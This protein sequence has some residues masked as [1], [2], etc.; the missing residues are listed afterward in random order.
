MQCSAH[1]PWALIERGVIRNQCLEPGVWWEKFEKSMET[2]KLCFTK[3]PVTEPWFRMMQKLRNSKTLGFQKKLH[4]AL[5]SSKERRELLRSSIDFLLKIDQLQVTHTAI[6]VLR[7]FVL[8]SAHLNYSNYWKYKFSISIIQ[9]K[10]ISGPVMNGHFLE[11]I[12]LYLNSMNQNIARFYCP[13][14]SWDKHVVQTFCQQQKW[15]LFNFVS[16]CLKKKF[17]I[18]Q[19]WIDISILFHT[20]LMTSA[21]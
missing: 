6:N 2:R 12:D 9:I 18:F 14:F 3:V 8:F 5:F 17:F 4:P 10:P 21:P 19:T 1:P 11:K 15:R 13:E 7:P 20:V 16:I